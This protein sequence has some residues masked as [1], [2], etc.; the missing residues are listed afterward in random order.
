[1]G[2]ARRAQGRRGAGA[3]GRGCSCGVI[4]T[5]GAQEPVPAASGLEGAERSAHGLTRLQA[6]S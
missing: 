2:D 5:G 1:M 3:P 4:P 6:G